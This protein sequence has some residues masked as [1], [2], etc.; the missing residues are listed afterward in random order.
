MTSAL[1][2][3]VVA[4]ELSMAALALPL[5]A[6]RFGVDG[7]AAAWVLLAYQLPLAALALPAGRW[8]DRADVRVVFTVSLA[9]IDAANV[10]ATATPMFSV[11]LVAQ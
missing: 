2:T 5:I 7:G 10:L 9:G 4:S 8:V 1:A 11:L 3:L 6:D